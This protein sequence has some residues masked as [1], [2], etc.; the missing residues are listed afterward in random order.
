MASDRTLSGHDLHLQ[1]LYCGRTV[2]D[3]GQE[4]PLPASFW[5]L[6]CNDAPGMELLLDGHALALPP[7]GMALVPAEC[8]G[9]WRCH[10]RLR[11]FYIHFHPLGL[12]AGWLNAPV[13]VPPAPERSARLAGLIPSDL[14]DPVW[15]LKAQALL[16][17]VWAEVLTQ[18]APG[19]R[20]R[21]L[22]PVDP[23]EALRGVIDHVEENPGEPHTI[24]GLAKRCGC[25]VAHFARR[26]R[27]HT[28]RSPKDWLCDLRLRLAR[29]RLLNSHDA[30]GA[31]AHDCGFANRHH[32]TRWFSRRYGLGPAAYRQALARTPRGE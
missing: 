23:A 14:H 21:F 26:L 2:L 22:A 31:I 4:C 5:R 30:I 28:G 13:L 19:L 12:P 24:S 7:L 27:A 10:T 11:H 15:R 29:D 17:S 6:Y 1:M 32:F 16:F 25:S 9:V 18:A 3:P 8:P 20:A